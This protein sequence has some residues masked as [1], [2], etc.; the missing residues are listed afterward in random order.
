[1]RYFSVLLCISFLHLALGAPYDPEPVLSR[2]IESGREMWIVTFG[3]TRPVSMNHWAIYLSP[4]PPSSQP[5]TSGSPLTR[6]LTTVKPDPKSPLSRPATAPNRIPPGRT[7]NNAGRRHK[8]S[9]AVAPIPLVLDA[10]NLPESDIWHLRLPG[11]VGFCFGTHDVEAAHDIL[12]PPKTSRYSP[13]N[14]GRVGTRKL[15]IDKAYMDSVTAKIIA[16]F[17]FHPTANNCQSWVLQ[18]LQQMVADGKLTQQE[19]D[20]TRHR[21]PHLPNRIDLKAKIKSTCDIIK[22]K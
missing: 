9:T 19:L 3:A 13:K 5:S 15:D 14:S 1:M 2:R 17:R 11:V 12:A 10:K 8:G 21:I 18:V 4:I 20:D 7:E 6:L 22:R 16:G